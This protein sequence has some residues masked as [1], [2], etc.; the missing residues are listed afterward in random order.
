MKFALNIFHFLA[1]YF[2]TIALP[3]RIEKFF[4]YTVM[5]NIV[6]LFKIME[7]LV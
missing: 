4:M 5:V 2:E 3:I 6:L 7:Q 1:L